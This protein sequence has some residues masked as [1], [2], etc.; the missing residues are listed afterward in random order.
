MI[1]KNKLEPCDVIFVKHKV[2][3]NWFAKVVHKLICWA[4]N[5]P[6]F[7]IA[8]V[9]NGN[10]IFEANG[11]RKAGYALLS[12]YDSYDV[13]RLDFSLEDRKQILSQILS[14]E[15]SS[16]DYGEIIS[17]FLRK[18]LKI[19]IFYDNTKKYICSGELFQAVRRIKNIDLLDQTT[20]DIAPSDL[21]GCS[22][23]KQVD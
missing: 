6:Y 23:L 16:Y 5:S 21:W 13:K 4:T 22:Y 11:L 9:V 18:R 2:K 3:S 20:E 12:D 17:L 1:D 10:L 15:G 8:Y 19:N 14:T 7:H